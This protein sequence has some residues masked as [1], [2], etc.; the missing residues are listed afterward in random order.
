CDHLFVAEAEGGRRET[1]ALRPMSIA[2]FFAASRAAIEAVGGTPAI[3]GRPSEMPDPVPFAEDDT[4]SP[5]DAAAV[6]RHPQALLR[7]AP[8]FEPFRT[9]FLGKVSPLHLF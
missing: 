2:Q 7:V 8:I 5:Y 4:T 9:C 6:P 3:H 1:F